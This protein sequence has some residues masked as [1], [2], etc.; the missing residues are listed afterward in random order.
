MDTKYR[1]TPLP[2]HT[3]CRLR[4]QRP[5]VGKGQVQFPGWPPTPCMTLRKPLVLKVANDSEVS[6]LAFLRCSFQKPFISFRNTGKVSS[7]WA[8]EW[9]AAAT[10]EER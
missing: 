6:N 9:G 3:L 2:A 1:F 7:I 8:G 5:V 4:K 10:E